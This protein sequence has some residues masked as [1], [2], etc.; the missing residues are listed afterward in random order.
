MK[1]CWRSL[2]VVISCTIVAITIQ[3]M[4]IW[5]RVCNMAVCYCSIS[6]G[7]LLNC[8]FSSSWFPS[9]LIG[10]FVEFVEEEE[11]HDG[12]HANE[13]DKC[14]RI[15]TLDE[16]QLECMNHNG[17]ELNHLEG[18][19]ILLPPEELL[20]FRSHSSQKIICIHNN[21]YKGVYKSK[22]STMSA[23]GKFNS[24]PY[25]H[26]H[27]S[28]MND[29]KCRY[30]L[31]L[32]SKYKEYCIHKFRK[33]WKIVPPAYMYHPN[34]EGMIRIVDWFTSKTIMTGKPPWH[35]YLIEEPRTE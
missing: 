1:I 15:V 3:C 17:D 27:Y 28:M 34:C 35:S 31:I 2:N 21:M 33:F 32:F 6:S 22:K 24:K 23:W 11:E 7:T 18:G 13:P 19:K 30:M 8:S 4:T 12:M 25:T 14:T 10:L 20:V 9:F 5:L 26:R 16:Q 29:V